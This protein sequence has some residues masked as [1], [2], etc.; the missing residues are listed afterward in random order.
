MTNTLTKIPNINDLLSDGTHFAEARGA[1]HHIINSLTGL[2]VM[3]TPARAGTVPL[4]YT[5]RRHPT[6]EVYWTYEQATEVV[7]IHARTLYNPAIVDIICSRIVE[8]QS[9]TDICRQPDIPSYVTLCRWRR[10]H[11]YINEM[12]EQARR[13]RAEAMRDK[14]LSEALAA[15]EDNVAAQRLKTDV[16]K[17]AASVD[18]PAK[19]SPK[20]KVDATVAVATKILIDTGIN[21]DI[22]VESTSQ[23]EKEVTKIEE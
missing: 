4:R 9:L 19:Y 7:T 22:P 18:D 16:L 2:V 6:G 14:A 20:T 23:I 8:G 10:Q 11:P 15:D 5:E 13:D 17:W 1:E 12:L 21:R 3:V